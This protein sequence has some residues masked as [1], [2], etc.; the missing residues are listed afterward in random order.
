MARLHALILGALFVAPVLIGSAE[1]ASPTITARKED[2]PFIKCEVCEEVAKQLSRQYKKIKESTPKLTEF[3]VIEMTERVCNPNRDEG[4]WI[5]KMDIVE[6]G[7]DRLKLENQ[8]VIG[9]CRSE[10][11]TIQ[12]ACEQVLGDHDTD[13]AEA[14]FAQDISRTALSKLLC[15]KLSKACVGPVPPLPED[16]EPGEEFVAGKEDQVK[17][18][19]MVAERDLPKSV[20]H[21]VRDEDMPAAPAGMKR[22]SREEMLA[23]SKG[24]SRES[25]IK[26]GTEPGSKQWKPSDLPDDLKFEL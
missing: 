20:F 24:G 2:I 19:K 18:D 12:K 9:E 8:D 25:G 15:R 4:E 26:P 6:V 23:K 14:L 22:L 13:V 11:K 16:R 1:S 21:N 5:A 7:T 17:M 10:C 3:Q